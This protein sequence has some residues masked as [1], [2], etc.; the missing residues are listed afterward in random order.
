MACNSSGVAGLVL[1]GFFALLVA[2][3]N[4]GG[5]RDS[6]RSSVAQAPVALP[7]LT[8]SSFRTGHCA[9]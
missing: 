2:M 8:E 7:T 3:C 4:G 6:Q 9:S 5:Q 1:V